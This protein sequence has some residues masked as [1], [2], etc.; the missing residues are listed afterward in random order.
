M[1]LIQPKDKKR[2]SD[3]AFDTILKEYKNAEYFIMELGFV[4]NKI[5]KD[6]ITNRKPITYLE[7]NELVNRLSFDLDKKVDNMLDWYVSM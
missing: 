3:V 4:Q 2:V 5:E 6:I 7:Y 1:T